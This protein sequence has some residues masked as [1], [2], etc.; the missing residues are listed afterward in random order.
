MV[1]SELR[2]NYS[3]LKE[4][5]V[6]LPDGLFVF[7]CREQ[8]SLHTALH[9]SRS[10]CAFMLLMQAARR[11]VGLAAFFLSLRSTPLKSRAGA[12]TAEAPVTA[13]SPRG[14]ARPHLAVTL[15]DNCF[16]S[17]SLIFKYQFLAIPVP[18]KP[19]FGLLGWKSGDYG[20]SSA[21]R[22]VW[23]RA[24]CFRCG[25]FST[26]AKIYSGVE[27]SDRINGPCHTRSSAISSL[28]HRCLSLT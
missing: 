17:D 4:K 12:T 27:R 8:S 9:F 3:P 1:F 18:D 21:A 23:R 15:H 7:L 10:L 5:A 6:L 20:N 14:R 13:G 22:P 26:Q 11:M 19:D 24:A 28:P 25:M 16:C 2:W